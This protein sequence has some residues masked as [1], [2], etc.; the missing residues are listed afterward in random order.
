SNLWFCG[1]SARCYLMRMTQYVA[2][3]T[4]W[5]RVGEAARCWGRRACPLMCAASYFKQNESKPRVARHYH[6]AWCATCRQIARAVCGLGGQSDQ[7]EPG[8]LSSQRE[9]ALAAG[10][11]SPVHV[12]GDPAPE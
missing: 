11:R 3:S 2:I 12:Q 5:V 10:G 7:G 6:L 1:L 8:D 4:D 9:Q